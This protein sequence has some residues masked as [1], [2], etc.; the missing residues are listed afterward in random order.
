MDGL[1]RQSA[2]LWS[3]PSSTVPVRLL[4]PPIAHRLLPTHGMQATSVCARAR[5]RARAR[6]D[7]IPRVEASLKYFARVPL[8]DGASLGRQAGASVR[9]GVA[10]LS[11]VT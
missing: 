6:V 4:V 5:V 2:Q 11:V 1:S 7:C 10:R 9:S 8:S 3:S